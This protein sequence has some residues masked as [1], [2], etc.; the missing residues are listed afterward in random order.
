MAQNH[1]EHPTWPD[2]YLRP[3]TQGKQQLD[4]AFLASDNSGTGPWTETARAIRCPA[5]LVT[6]DP[7]QGGIVT[8]EVAEEVCGLNPKIQV[9]N[10]PGIGHHIRFAVHEAYMKAVKQ[11]LSNIGS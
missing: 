7:A 3:W 9:V 8:P 6:A 2:R 5:L 10:F 4:L 11:F 1:A